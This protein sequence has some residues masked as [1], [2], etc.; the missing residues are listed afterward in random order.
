MGRFVSGAIRA[1]RLRLT[2]NPY[3]ATDY[4]WHKKHD[5][6][7]VNSA[8]DDEDRGYFGLLVGT[9]LLTSGGS[10]NQTPLTRLSIMVQHRRRG[11]VASLAPAALA[12]DLTGAVSLGLISSMA[13]PLQPTD[14]YLEGWW[15]ADRIGGGKVLIRS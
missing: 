7:N 3:S 5:D 10:N 14:V 9:S 15:L 11:A 6:N 1:F 12:A 13:P 8:G 4:S 2:L